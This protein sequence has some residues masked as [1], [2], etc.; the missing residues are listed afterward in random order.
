MSLIHLQNLEFQ[1]AGSS[2]RLGPLSLELAAG[3]RTALVGPSGCGKSTL[4]RIL[5]GLETPTGGVV[6][7]DGKEASVAGAVK[8]APNARGMGL[9][10][11]DGALWPHMTALEHLRFV[12]PE[13]SKDD[14]KALLARV[15]LDGKEQRRPGKLSG[16][17]MQRLALARALARE[18]EVLLLDEPLASVD[19]HLRDDLALL[20]RKIAEESGLSLVVVTHDR[21]EALAMADDVVVL[22]Q[23]QVVER[24]SAADLIDAPKTAFSARFLAHAACLELE[25]LGGGRVRSAF[26]EHEL[27][28]GSGQ[29]DEHVLAILPGDA[30][31]GVNGDAVAFEATVTQVRPDA[32]GN[33]YAMILVDGRSLFV[34]C[35]ASVRSGAR[36]GLRLTRAPRIL[37]AGAAFGDQHGGSPA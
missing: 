24:G 11:Q 27:P 9:V 35:D 37:P 17:E 32:F 33:R 8:I 22:H 4:L 16:G 7:I 26:G 20:V 13:L 23:G 2:F 14:A 34:P 36:V 18:P 5:A 1:R 3:S 29:G 10:F 25:H 21:E 6:V 19:V 28:A 30:A 15:G 12:A 31:I